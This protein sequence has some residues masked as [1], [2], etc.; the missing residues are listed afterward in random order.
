MTHLNGNKLYNES[1]FVLSPPLPLL[2]LVLSFR[3]CVRAKKAPYVPPLL[4]REYEVL[5]VSDDMLLCP[6]YPWRVPA[7]LGDSR[8]V[9]VILTPVSRSKELLFL[10]CPRRFWKFMI[11]QQITFL[12]INYH[13]ILLPPTQSAP[14]SSPSRQRLIKE[15]LICFLELSSLLRRIRTFYLSFSRVH[16]LYP[17]GVGWRILNLSSKLYYKVIWVNP[18]FISMLPSNSPFHETIL[19]IFLFYLFFVIPFYHCFFFLFFF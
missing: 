4:G 7:T 19:L 18:P 11:G 5:C 3:C 13:W 10:F 9:K 6:H 12:T 17:N 1:Y 14:H 2:L 15:T 16:P 8:M